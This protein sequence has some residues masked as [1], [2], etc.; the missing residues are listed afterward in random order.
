MIP[1]KAPTE[2][3]KKQV[4][5]MTQPYS[6]DRRIEGGEIG[7]GYDYDTEAAVA[8]LYLY[9]EQQSD[10]QVEDY[11]GVN[12]GGLQ[13]LCLPD[14]DVQVYDR[15]GYGQGRY[16]VIEPI[17]GIPNEADPTIL[18]LSFDRVEATNTG[19]PFA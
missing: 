11:G 19:E 6:I 17:R 5:R 18:H 7:G 2:P 13:G 4:Q 14:A 9:D 1:G 12:R 16:E 15:V 3:I 8:E 10:I